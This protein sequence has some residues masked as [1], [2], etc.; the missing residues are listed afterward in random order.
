M[1]SRTG[2]SREAALDL[3]VNRECYLGADKHKPIPEPISRWIDGENRNTK[4]IAYGVF[5]LSFVPLIFG[6]KIYNSLE[7]VMITKLVLVLGYLSFVAIFLVSWETKGEILSGF[8]RFGEIPEG[9]SWATLAAFAAYAGAGGR[10]PD[11]GFIAG[12]SSFAA[13]AS[14]FKAHLPS[15][16]SHFTP[17]G[18]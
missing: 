10:G 14:S 7:R 9:V 1:A 18:W 6:G 3:T 5:L 2:I 11:A 13:F 16:S 8:L 15:S 17:G 12:T 4:R